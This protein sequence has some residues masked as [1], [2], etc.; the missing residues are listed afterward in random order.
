MDARV[1]AEVPI[2]WHVAF[3]YAKIYLASLRWSSTFCL[4]PPFTHV[5][6]KVLTGSNFIASLTVLHFCKHMQVGANMLR[7]LVQGH[8]CALLALR[9][10]A[11]RR[12]A[13][14][15]DACNYDKYSQRQ[16]F[17]GLSRLCIC[18]ESHLCRW[19][20]DVQH[21]AVCELQAG[22]SEPR[23]GPLRRT[24]TN[25]DVMNSSGS[26]TRRRNSRRRRCNVRFS[27]CY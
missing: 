5:R 9:Q 16:H 6:L 25:Y 23:A 14:L 19:L 11:Q 12:F 21:G 24:Q 27:V 7:S 10:E 1:A 20:P 13:I 22:R 26:N 15:T 3:V 18:A 2:G 4:L 17:P 8:A